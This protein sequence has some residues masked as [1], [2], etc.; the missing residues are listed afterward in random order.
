M[1]RRSRFRYNVLRSTRSNCLTKIYTMQD[2]VTV[3]IDNASECMHKIET[4]LEKVDPSKIKPL[5]AAVEEAL[6]HLQKA[7]KA[8]FQQQVNFALSPDC[9]SPFNLV[10]VGRAYS[11]FSLH[12][13]SRTVVLLKH[14]SDRNHEED[15]KSASE[16]LEGL[17]RSTK[18]HKN[19]SR[20]LTCMCRLSYTRSPP[21]LIHRASFF[22]APMRWRLIKTTRRMYEKL[23]RVAR[24]SLPTMEFVVACSQRRPLLLAT[25]I[26][27]TWRWWSSTL[28]ARDQRPRTS[29]SS[30]GTV[31]YVTSLF[32]VLLEILT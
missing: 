26:L 14:V 4:I 29:L 23:S 28:S 8:S 9:F 19:L 3:H 24:L 17:V 32:L 20:S 16:R 6:R 25:W 13:P 10:E 27:I 5:T 2:S 1:T 31:W 30:P 18:M 21:T 7:S 11:R 22:T 12:E 15:P